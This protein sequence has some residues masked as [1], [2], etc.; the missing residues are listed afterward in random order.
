MIKEY[1]KVNRVV[2]RKNL[3]LESIVVT[4]Y[5]YSVNPPVSCLFQFV[6]ATV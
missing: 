6:S 4:V 1:A 3:L 5:I 2:H